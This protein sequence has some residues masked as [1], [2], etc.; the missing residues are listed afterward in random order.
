MCKSIPYNDALRGYSLLSQIPIRIL[1]GATKRTS[2]GQKERHD[3]RLEV[4]I[5]LPLS[6]SMLQLAQVRR[7]QEDVG[8][9]VLKQPVPMSLNMSSEKVPRSF[10]WKCR[11]DSSR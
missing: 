11:N 9:P 4:T 6:L 1:E 3:L 7:D 5:A 8:A 2:L 10:T